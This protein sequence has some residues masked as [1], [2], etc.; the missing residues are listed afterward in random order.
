MPLKK[1]YLTIFLSIFFTLIL[2]LGGIWILIDDDFVKMFPDNIES[3]KVWD[4]IQD[5]F[6]TTEYLTVALSGSKIMSDTLM[7]QNVISYVSNIEKIKD[8]KG[9]LLI[10]RVLSITNSNFSNNIDKKQKFQD[11][12]QNLI[13]RFVHVLNKDSVYL[14]IYIVPKINVNNTELVKRVKNITNKKLAGYDIHYAGQPYLSG[15][16]PDLISKDVRKLMLV[17]LGIMLLVLGI[18]FKS[19]YAVSSVMLTT[20]FALI[21]MLGFMGWLYMITGYNMFNFTILS[22]S[23]PIILLTIA[24]SDGVHIVS[25]FFRE[26]KK[27]KNIKNALSNTLDSL[28]IPIFLTSITTAIA[29]ISMVFSPIPHMIGY[30]I[31]I[32]FGVV[33]A[34]ILSLSFLPAVLILK[35]WNVDSNI[36]HKDSFIK[37]T[38]KLLSEK[39]NQYPK[40]I[41]LLSTLLVLIASIGIGLI[42]V[43][44]NIIKFFKKG[45]PIRESSDFVDDKMN[46]SMSLAIEAKGDFTNLENIKSL[47]KLQVYIDDNF[48]DVK[49]SMS[50][51]T[52]LKEI[53]RNLALEIEVENP[54]DYY[55]IPSDNDELQYVLNFPFDFGNLDKEKFNSNIRYIVDIAPDNYKQSS[56]L[57]HQIKSVSTEKA[58]NITDKIKVKIKELKSE[59]NQVDFYATGF[60]V[61]LKEFVSMV[62]QSS[63][64]SIFI[65][66]IVIA[67]VAY[68]VLKQSLWSFLSI[69]PLSTAVILNF[70]L[71]G[72][73]G[74]ELSH[75][76]ALLTA[77][78]IGVGVDFSIHYI[79][80]YKYK[81]EHSASSLNINKLTF[82]DV[83]YPILLDVGSNL[84]FAALL[85]SSIVPLNY[86][87]GLIVFAMLFTSFGTLT[88]LSSLIEILEKRLSGSS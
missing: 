64:L 51:A 16:V 85:F 61:F 2:S 31:V 70:G 63:I 83:G 23:M 82:Q 67:I 21:G 32:A 84:G 6:G 15:E 5:K 20:I 33:W 50:Y 22:T 58:A 41:L 48:E 45:T 26:V 4:S 69:V 53:N 38:L 36:F 88:I 3:K 81:L 25:R 68:W 76:T 37:K 8:Q 49:R 72:F 24:N 9:D 52:I 10:E 86:M 40:K 75:L 43:E 1:P 47:D 73:L 55:K 71:M 39:V 27:Q 60:L 56:L 34:W 78:I 35:N 87:G 17:G 14:S 18:N 80:D 44:V 74:I 11:Y 77:I 42:K 54:D 7:H 62:I 30:G 13:D 65:S 59:N 28:K 46:G 66:I 19:V 57:L 79:S 12:N 29:F